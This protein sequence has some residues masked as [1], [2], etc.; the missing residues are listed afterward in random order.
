VRYFDYEG[1]IMTGVPVDAH[2]AKLAKDLYW[3]ADKASETSKDP[4]SA[5]KFGTLTKTA[6]TR[7]TFTQVVAVPVTK[8]AIGNQRRVWLDQFSQNLRG[9]NP[10]RRRTNFGGTAWPAS[11]NGPWTLP[12]R[13]RK[14]I[15]LG[16]VRLF[17]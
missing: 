11:A 9:T 6:A 2:Y 12:P 14:T 10:H 15:T 17:V 13:R 3:S 8:V 1:K 7:D 4:S 16:T 5:F